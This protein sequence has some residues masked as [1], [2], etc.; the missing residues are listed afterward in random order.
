MQAAQV[1]SNGTEVD[2]RLTLFNSGT[3]AAKSLD[4][5]SVSLRTLGGSGQASVLSGAPLLIG[6]LAAGDTAAVTLKLQ[7]PASVTKLSLTEQVSFDSGKPELT[8][9][10]GGQVL[11][12]KR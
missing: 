4:L 2:V 11:Y 5:T 6:D 10:S 9:A 1:A 8:Q 7:I 3:E 12:P